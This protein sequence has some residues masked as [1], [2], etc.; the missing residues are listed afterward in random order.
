MTSDLP[1]Q[2]QTIIIGGG[3]IGCSLAY[4]LTELGCREVLLLEQ[5]RLS[6]GTT[7]HAAGLVGQLRTHSNLTRLIRASTE[8]YAGLEARTGLATGWK[9]CGSISVARTAERMTQLRRT[10]SAARAQGV[11]AALLSAREAADKWP[12]MRS[13][14]LHG[15]VW[16]PGDGKANPSDITQALAR[17]ARTGGARI[18]E[19]VR[20]TGFRLAQRTVVG[21]ETTHGPV[22][23]ERVAICA[24][25]WSREVG[26]LCGVAIPLHSAEHMYVI[27]GR[28]AGVTPELPVMRDPDG[29][30][31]FKEEVGG[32][33]MGGF[34]P[35]A[36]P[37]GMEGVPA[38][39]AFQLLPDD[40]DQFDPLM[41]SALHR[42]PALRDAEIK[43]FINGP[44]SFT[45]DGGFILGA[46]PEMAGVFV[47]AGFNSAGIASAGGAG[48]AL[49]EWMLAGEPS[50]DLW[51]VDIRRFARF[52]GNRRWLGE[53]VRESLGLHYAMAWPNR[54]P[55][56]ARPLRRSPLYDRLAAK[57]AVFGSKMGWERANWF[58]PHGASR[59]TDYSFGRQNW[60]DAVANEHRACRERV[61]LFDLTSFAKLLVQ[62]RDAERAL[63]HLCANDIALPVGRSAYTPMLNRRGGY[64]SD[65]TVARLAPEIFLLLTGTA[66]ATRDSDWIRRHIPD[67]ACAVLTDVT[68]AFAVLAVAGPQSRALL[69]RVSRVALDNAAFPPGAVREIDIGHATGWAMR[70]SYAGE[71]GWELV[72][73]SEFAATAYD[74]LW[75][76]GEE[77]G[78]VDAGYY[79]LELLRIEKGYRA[80]GRELTP[81]CTPWAAGLGFAVKLGKAT[82]FIGRDALLAARAQPLHERLACLLASVPDAPLAWGGE[83]VSAGGAE[84]GELTS[85]A[86]GHS[87]GGMVALGW[88]R[89]ADAPLDDAWL[90][91]QR[92]FVDVAGEPVAVRA[93]LAP[94]WDPGGAR[95]RE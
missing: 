29:Y 34:E 95:L 4:H 69:S 33:A 88:V 80:W 91:G 58:A 59:Q 18:V 50:F 49:A 66:Q 20:V 24:G 70:R 94:F 68:S 85:A 64:E 9:Q 89:R 32:L 31:Y 65:L 75:D 87:V 51:P 71:L 43:S 78:L 74:A 15:A 83:L 23:C 30:I 93:Q 56:S 44:E 22:A 11:E 2:A 6:C 77:L 37:W 60:F 38:G 54:E 86:Y 52:H 48:R 42:V 7:W 46:A 72:L 55:A 62:G 21:V 13:D 5:G 53:R 47:G 45:S 82:D 41:Q 92:F 25:Q 28:I 14:D 27:T 1:T 12:L 57:G 73:P 67:G 3:I 90:A 8:L 17:G 19:G 35:D 61:A 84:A 81:D 10:A 36:K 63:Q 16:L 76:A 39:F 26:E 79:T 40:W